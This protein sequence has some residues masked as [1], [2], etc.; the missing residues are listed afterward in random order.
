MIC[1]PLTLREANAY[2]VTHHR[3][4]GPTKGCRFCLG[5]AVGD[6]IVGV[7]IVGRPVARRLD[8]GFTVEVVRLA[9][10]GT[11]NACSFLYAAA[12][13]AAFALGYRRCVTY[14]LDSEPG[15]SLRAA[16]FRLLG[17][18]GGGSWSRLS[19]PWI[20]THPLQGKLCWEAPA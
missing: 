19:R 11:Q 18:A 3:H 9:T 4:H 17:E 13:R 20:D 8:D 14:I 5:A 2:V 6:H 1:V 15:T 16:G 10:D 7:A 12:R